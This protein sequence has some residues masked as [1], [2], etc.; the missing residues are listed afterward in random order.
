MPSIDLVGYQHRA[1]GFKIITR[2]IIGK[3]LVV[4]RRELTTAELR[5]INDWPGVVAL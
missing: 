5:F 3:V 2:G 4:P 1:E